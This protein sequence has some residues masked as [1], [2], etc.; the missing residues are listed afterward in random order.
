MKKKKLHACYVP[1]KW[2]LK[3]KDCGVTSL[4][5]HVIKWKGQ[6]SKLLD[7]QSS[8]LL[9]GVCG[10]VETNMYG[11]PPLFHNSPKLKPSTIVQPSVHMND[12]K[13]NMEAML[14]ALLAKKACNL[15]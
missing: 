15:P 1:T 2:V 13:A 5:D 8:S 10:P 11:A 4:T 12:Q 14:V 9:P 3:H 6:V 7:A